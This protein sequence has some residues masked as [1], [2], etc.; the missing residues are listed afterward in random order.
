MKI[1]VLDQF[2][3]DQLS[4]SQTKNIFGG[5]GQKE[6]KTLEIDENGNP[7]GGNNNG[8]TDTDPDRDVN[9]GVSNG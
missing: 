8:D 9:G 4:K 5:G 7:I 3:E 1:S 6:Q 2:K